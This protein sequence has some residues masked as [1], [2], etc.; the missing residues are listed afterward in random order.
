MVGDYAGRQCGAQ[1]LTGGVVAG[2]NA[3][4]P[5]ACL[6][7][8]SLC[9]CLAEGTEENWI[10]STD[11]VR[12]FRFLPNIFILYII[13]TKGCPSCTNPEQRT[14]TQRSTGKFG[15]MQREA[16]QTFSTQA[17]RRRG[18]QKRPK[19]HFP[20]RRCCGSFLCA[21]SRHWRNCAPLRGSSH[22]FRQK[23]APVKMQDVRHH[24]R[25]SQRC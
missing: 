18:K 11:L 19:T 12:I 7:C 9:A 13:H 16:P 22:Q 21:A 17:V 10:R 3:G 20:N 14:S 8:V 5:M 23:H 24:Q 1:W 2:S 6:T 15:S 25:R 4:V